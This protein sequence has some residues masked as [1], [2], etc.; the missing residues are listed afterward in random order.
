MTQHPDIARTQ[1][2]QNVVR[3]VLVRD[4]VIPDDVEYVTAQTL[5]FRQLD[6]ELL[7]AGEKVVAG[8]DRV[9]E[10]AELPQI[11]E[12]GRGYHVD[13]GQCQDALSRLH[14]QRVVA[15]ERVLVPRGVVVGGIEQERLVLLRHPILHELAQKVM[16]P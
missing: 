12:D 1:L 8:G 15:H 4:V 16:C 10:H 9:V 5:L 11:V 6:R 7:V 2:G 14:N 13:A 3:L